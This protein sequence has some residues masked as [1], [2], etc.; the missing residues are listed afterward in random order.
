MSNT[1]VL[2]IAG[3]PKPAQDA[4]RK[5]G[6]SSEEM[7]RKVH[8]AGS[9]FDEAGERAGALDTRAMGFRDTLTGV[10]DS[11]KGVKSIASGDWGFE[12]LLT[13]GAGIGDLASGFENFLIPAMKSAT[14][15]K[16]AEN[17]AWLASPI[18]WVIAGIIAL[19]A[20]IVLIAT[21]T[22]W[23]SKAWRAAWDW[24]KDA[25][26]AVGS[27]FKD[28]LWEKWI[29]GAWDAI[30]NK[31]V[32]VYLWMRDLPG[33]LKGAF[34][35]VGDFIAAPFRAGFNL[36]STAWNNTVGRLHW[37]VPGWIPGIGGNSFSA[38]T[39][40]HFHSGGVVGGVPGSEVLA[41]LQAGE[42]VTP[43][44]ASAGGGGD[45][46]YVRGDALVDTL[47]E[48]IA[49]EVGRRGGNAQ[50]VLGGRNG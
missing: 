15:A 47:I 1:V 41:V 11:V 3:D 29:Q 37:T 17:A 45:T 12:S 34:A 50:V 2:T 25:A 18:T 8:E 35:K 49:R 10:Q 46:V 42:R 39:L 13:L 6:D 14:I 36:V 48:L 24:I 38:P 27:W 23:F 19:V 30:L 31:A 26:H 20:V 43:A 32:S 40:P 7:G 33:K 28:V 21:K 9:S 5:V 44:V 22:D 4:F 16:W